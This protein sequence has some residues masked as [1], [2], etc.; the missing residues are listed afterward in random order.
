MFFRKYLKRLGSAV[1]WL[2]ADVAWGVAQGVGRPLAIVA[3]GEAGWAYRAAGRLVDAR[4]I[5]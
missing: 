2:L 3:C 4:Q 1:A 5:A